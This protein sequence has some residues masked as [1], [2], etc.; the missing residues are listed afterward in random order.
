M[1]F[2]TVFLFV[3]AFINC[4]LAIF[5]VFTSKGK[6]S[7]SYSLFL[8]SI[9]A[10]S[11]GLA[12]FALETNPAAALFI[13]NFYYLAA[14]L[15]AASFLHFSF[16]FLRF[17]TGLPCCVSFLYLPVFFLAFVLLMD[18]HVLIGHIEIL[19]G[20]KEVSLNFFSYLLYS[21]FF[22]VYVAWSY[23]N[24][25]KTYC[26][27]KEKTAIIQLKL[28]IV[29][30]LI[31]FILA[32]TSNL[33]LPFLGRYDYIWLGPFFSLWMIM[34]V[35][36]AVTRHRLFNAKVIAT[37]LFVFA[38]WLFIF[39][40][41]FLADSLQGQ[42]TEVI[43]LLLTVIVGIFLIRSVLKE[44]QTRQ[45]IELLAIRLEKANRELRKSDLLKS[46][47]VSL[48]TH[49][50]RSPLTAIKG[51]I[52]LVLEGSYGTIS[53]EVRIVLERV[54]ESTESLVSVVQ[55]FLDVSRIDQGKMRYTFKVFDLRE[56]V[57]HVVNELTP[58]IKEAG[59]DVSFEF[60]Q[61]EFYIKGDKSKVRQVVLNL[62][63]N[64]IKYTPRGFVKI[65]LSKQVGFGENDFFSEENKKEGAASYPNSSKKDTKVIRLCIED[66][67][68]GM[69]SEDQTRLFNK[70]ARA[71]DADATDIS[72]TGL[73]LYIARSIVEAH[74]GKV[75]AVSEGK[76]RGSKFFVEFFEETRAD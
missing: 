45:E 26:K 1:G 43:L 25:S 29:G 74:H 8:L 70:F 5:M 3:I 56:V 23:F 69:D 6:E 75:W 57:R 44:V 46:E 24:L 53:Q 54:S 63:D 76:G 35:G 20:Q 15:I 61:E 36:Y 34:L 11:V 71:D 37:E 64:A 16:V 2:S 59:P 17:K 19:D 72:G 30:T 58:P 33:I 22:I 67:G 38:I 68:V 49:Q 55:D 52:S 9:A 42:I 62:L 40:R 50:I 18:P 60:P 28:V 32:S 73:G 47:I 48:A 12:F 66:S 31:G 21:V 65:S 14:A 10:W 51:F 41:I 27:E 7:L 39:I 13:A 4:T